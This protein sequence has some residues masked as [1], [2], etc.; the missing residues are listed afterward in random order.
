M[1]TTDRHNTTIDSRQF[2]Q[3]K[4]FWLQRLSGRL[5][6]SRFPV[7]RHSTDRADELL[8]ERFQLD[9]TLNEG[10]RKLGNGSDK[11]MHMILTAVLA[12]LLSRYTN[13][14]DVLLGTPI[15]RQ[16]VEGDF[17]NKVLPLRLDIQ[18]NKS[19]KE[20]LLQ[21]RDTLSAAVKHQNYP[22]DLLTGQ[23][24]SPA[25]EQGRGMFD[26]MIYLLNIHDPS[27]VSHLS[28]SVTWEFNRLEHGFEGT[29]KYRPAQYE[30]QTIQ[31]FIDHFSL[32][33][34]QLSQDV[35][36]PAGHVDIVS[37]GERK[38]L[39]EEFNR[40]YDNEVEGTTLASLF[41]AQVERTPGAPAIVGSCDSETGIQP[42]SYGELNR[43]A[44]R[45]AHHL[46]QLGAGPGTI[47]CIVMKPS[48]DMA[49]GLWAILKAGACYLPVDPDYP[50]DSLDY[51]VKESGAG[52]ILTGNGKELSYPGVQVVDPSSEAGD[53]R[54]LSGI[55]NPEDPAYII[56]TSG[57]TGRPKGVVVEHR[58]IANTL[59][60][61]REI[62][63][64]DEQSVSLQLLSFMF[65]AFVISFFTPLAGGGAVVLLREEEIRDIRLV[66]RTIA[67]RKVSHL[68]CVPTLYN[69]LIQHLTPEEAAG[70]RM[71]T[72]GGD[73]LS[74]KLLA[75]TGE[76]NRD[77]EIVNEYGITEAA[78]TTTL[79]RHQELRDDIRVGSPINN[80]FVVVLDN[81]L[82]LQPVGVPGELCVGGRGISRGY[83]NNP[84][85][86]QKKFVQNPFFPG[87]T[88]YRSGDWAR[89]RPDGTL[90]LMGR[91]D[92]QVKIRGYRIELL[93]I[94]SALQ[95]HPGVSEAVVTA[96][97]TLRGDRLLAAFLVPVEAGA[98]PASELE[99][100]LLRRLPDY[101]VPRH[102][103]ELGE[104]PLTAN[105]KVDRNQ[106][107]KVALAIQPH[108]DYVAPRDPLQEKL[109]DIWAKVL[110][111]ETVGIHD[112]FF[113]AGGDSIRSI[114]LLSLVNQ[115]FQTQFKI[116]E[117]Y[118]ADTIEA[119]AKKISDKEVATD[120]KAERKVQNKVADLKDR[121]LDQL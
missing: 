64:L 68:V 53:G 114:S 75:A 71:V 102:F 60:A 110:E 94:E 20:L 92:D 3:Y 66:C 22:L 101:M 35:A 26:V 30:P 17:I 5:P 99:E 67:A 93:E 28:P 86:T 74:S 18:D 41:E 10:I 73:R 34:G 72:L 104:L 14:S 54:N 96:H 84:D 52:F 4:T 6:D 29:I 116:V 61:R 105:G 36:L 98:V 79:Q 107:A 33:L 69:V 121:F 108:N 51:L 120:T 44:N 13:Q 103:Q 88:M 12:A 90:E 7:D 118:E 83:L 38:R 1:N 119:F 76:K 8:E 97:E 37:V 47:V 109:A 55:S 45:L 43:R 70:I 32:M 117:L 56:F 65:D 42:L 50:R 87:E 80:T 63:T 85:L 23:L 78:V 39:L 81:R 112:H 21:V 16:Q 27:Y 106:L 31:R 2:A 9:G 91:M 77:I 62:Y 25:I 95:S 15:Y 19:F 113:S 115:E 40:S 57:T 89:W 82:R 59:A 11:R 100:F 46:R 111:V 24:D 48:L 49:V 58:N